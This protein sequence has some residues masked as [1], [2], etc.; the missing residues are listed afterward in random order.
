M[1][2]AIQ[3]PSSPH[4]NIRVTAIGD[5]Q[6]KAISELFNL[7][8]EMSEV[9]PLSFVIANESE[10]GIMAIAVTWT[11][12][13]SSGASAVSKFLGD[14]YLLATPKPLIKSH[15]RAL[16]LPDEVVAEENVGLVQKGIINTLKRR[17]ARFVSFPTVELQ[18]DSIIFE[19]GEIMGPNQ[20][21]M[22]EVISGR[23]QAAKELLLFKSK[24]GD[25]NIDLRN[26]ELAKFAKNPVSRDH[27]SMWK[28][29]FAEDI[30]KSSHQ[31]YK[32]AYLEKL[33]AQPGA[34]YPSTPKCL[35]LGFLGHA[36]LLRLAS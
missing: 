11:G 31:E 1:K 34:F 13:D 18:I 36:M 35:F 4:S 7:H 32:W 6:S 21:G 27:A 8:P 5:S 23:R 30:L 10:K 33:A 17:V 26:R 9:S 19:D 29:R 24:L 2:Q 28:S 3:L 14:N 22:D 25:E 12:R 15:S 20:L 16:I